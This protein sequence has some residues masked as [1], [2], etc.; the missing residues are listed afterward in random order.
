MVFLP[1]RS[2]VFGVV[3]RI[4]FRYNDYFYY[5]KTQ[6]VLGHFIQ[7]RAG[8]SKLAHPPAQRRIVLRKSATDDSSAPSP[9][10]EEAKRTVRLQ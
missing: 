8:E 4:T 6:S 5:I 2:P 1:N 3:E 10:D 9:M 7:I